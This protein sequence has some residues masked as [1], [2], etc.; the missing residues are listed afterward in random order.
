MSRRQGAE[1]AGETVVSKTRAATGDGACLPS[2][3]NQGHGETL[4][5]VVMRLKPSEVAAQFQRL[6]ND[7]PIHRADRIAPPRDE[8]LY[9]A[10]L[11]FRL[12]C[13]LPL[14]RQDNDYFEAQRVKYD[15]ELGQKWQSYWGLSLGYFFGRFRQGEIDE[16]DLNY[17]IAVVPGFMYLHAPEFA[18]RSLVSHAIPPPNSAYRAGLWAAT[19]GCDLAEVRRVKSVS[20]LA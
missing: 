2:G 4:T 3:Y 17:V 5:R 12:S 20:L 7:L 8:F 11:G 1:K 16:S 9:M 15:P 6:L 19:A 10:S 18:G 14:E 13:P